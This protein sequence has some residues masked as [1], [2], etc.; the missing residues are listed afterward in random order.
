M[1]ITS[2]VWLEFKLALDSSIQY[3]FSSIAPVYFLIS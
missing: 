1:A 3:L 2:T